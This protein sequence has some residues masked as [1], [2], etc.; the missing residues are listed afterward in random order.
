MPRPNRRTLMKLGATALVTAATTA[1]PATAT[2]ATARPVP[3]ALPAVLPSALSAALPVSLPAPTARHPV[4]TVELH[5]V[6][7]TR[8]DPLLPSKPF[9][10]LMV[11]V[12]YP[13]ER[14]G[15][16]PT[17]P[18]L[19]PAAAADW[20][21][22]SAPGLTIAPGAVDWPGIHTHA[23]TGAPVARRMGPLP[24]VLFFPG[25]G[26]TRALGT[27]LVE[28]LAAHGYVVITVDSTY[29]AD[30]VEFPGGRVERAVP[31]PDELT[32][33]VIAALLAKHSRA[34]LADAGFVLGRIEALARGHNPDAEAQ[35]LPGGLSTALDLSRVGALGQSLG[36]SVAAQLAH[37]DPRVGAAV[38]LDGEF[39]GP[40]AGTGVTAPFLL[41]ASGPHTFGNVPGWDTFWAAST[42]WKRALR[43]RGSAHGS[44]TDLQVILPQLTPYLEIPAAADLIGTIT[45]HR[46]LTAQR[47]AVRAFF[48]HHLKNRPTGFFERPGARYPEVEVM[49]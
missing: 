16:F 6:D 40:V 33:E 15:T 31:L 12:W 34:R 17:A 29:E 21:S 38:N 36:G 35:P 18:W 19:R 24:V 2:P 25:D 49:G 48:D 20:D 44:Y 43:L 39:I 47:A 7:R 11:G 26:G 30:Q 41:M 32:P 23:R 9:R 22:H 28:E 27:T 1:T 13:A 37:D 3:R 10:E 4:G 46:S 42:G 45:P 8:P 5:L 14:G